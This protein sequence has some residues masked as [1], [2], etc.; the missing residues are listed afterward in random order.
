MGAGTS[1]P[2]GL[3]SA[4]IAGGGLHLM[5]VLYESYDMELTYGA[6]LPWLLSKYLLNSPASSK[7]RGPRIRTRLEKL[8]NGI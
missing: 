1:G 5:L 3:L 2:A 4:S 6:L 7:G 8:A